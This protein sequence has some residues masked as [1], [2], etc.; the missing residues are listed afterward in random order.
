[1]RSKIINLDATRRTWVAMQK[2][3]N[4]EPLTDQEWAD[5]S[6]LTLIDRD[7]L[8]FAPGDCRWATT[9]TE[10]AD[11][12]LFYQSLGSSCRGASVVH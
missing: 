4:D 12:L 7:R 5:L 1:M 2:F 8:E 11:N 3:A 9:E 6:W 10:R